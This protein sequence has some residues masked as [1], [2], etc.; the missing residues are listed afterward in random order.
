M[1]LRPGFFLVCLG[2]GVA[3]GLPASGQPVRVSHRHMI[4]AAEPLAAEAGL[5]ALR[6]GGSAVDAAIAAQATL[7]LVEPQASGVGGGAP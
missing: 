7:A 6:E 5:A 3:F 2:L 1:R 4:V